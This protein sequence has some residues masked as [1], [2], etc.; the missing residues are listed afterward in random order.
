MVLS[1][2]CWFH[3]QRV[4]QEVRKSPFGYEFGS[5]AGPQPFSFRL[6]ELLGGTFFITGFVFLVIDLIGWVDD[7]RHA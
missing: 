2:P 4:L 1:I 6:V 3:L 7:R 5:V